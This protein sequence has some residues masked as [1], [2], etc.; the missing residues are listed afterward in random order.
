MTRPG[1][2]ALAAALVLVVGAPAVD[3]DDAP[4]EASREASRWL[5]F[6]ALV[7]VEWNDAAGHHTELLTVR[8]R[9][10]KMVV[11]GGRDVAASERARF[12]YQHGLGWTLVWPASLRV[13]DRPRPQ[14]KYRIVERGSGPTIAG[15]STEVVEVRRRGAVW[16]RLFVD[17]D[18]GLALRREQYGA[19][20][21][22][23]RVVT[24]ELL[25]TGAT[26]V[27][28]P[29]VTVDHSP[30][31]VPGMRPSAPYRAPE[32]LGAGYRLVGAYRQPDGALH[33]LYSDGVYD[34]SVFEKRGR[35]DRDD[36]PAARRHVSLAGGRDGWR[37][38]WPGG[39]VV[40]WQAGGAV[41]TA[42]GG[43]PFADVLAA[44][45]TMPSAGSPSVAE[46]LRR[47]CRTFLD[48]FA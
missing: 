33:L 25:V 26:P 3:A 9:D 21:I 17:A 6:E 22:P 34:L 30:D 48:M 27:S 45:R 40:V 16:E 19:D 5:A 41:F 42:V 35:L 15:R 46:K 47:M 43:A 11:D 36:L 10:G 38:A 24:F 13:D 18:T 4:I 12:V 1:V 28:V 39:E 7:R 2:V 23:R 29:A 14:T 31:T 32:E 20:G 44:A 8:S 37:V